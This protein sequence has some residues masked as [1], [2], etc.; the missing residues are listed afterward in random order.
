MGQDAHCR[1][2]S[3]EQLVVTY[4]PAWQV[5]HCPLSQDMLVVRVHNAVRKVSA[6]GHLGVHEVQAVSPC[7]LA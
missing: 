2:L 3:V 7:E 6:M 4:W 1:L 5:V